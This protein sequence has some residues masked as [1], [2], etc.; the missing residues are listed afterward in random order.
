MKGSFLIRWR[1]FK[2]HRRFFLI[3]NKKKLRKSFHDWN[4]FDI[5][6]QISTLVY[7]YRVF[8]P[9]KWILRAPE[10]QL[11]KQKNAARL[12][13]LRSYG[14][15]DTLMVFL[16]RRHF[17]SIHKFIPVWF[18]KKKNK[19]AF[20]SPASLW[21]CWHYLHAVYSSLQLF[22]RRSFCSLTSVP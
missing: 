7:D 13:L 14:F 3:Y 19:K 2:N 11:K 20:Y 8:T 12:S 18:E 15:K 5:L 9:H 1:I 4:F 10:K 22:I 6:R 17:S 16:W 21:L